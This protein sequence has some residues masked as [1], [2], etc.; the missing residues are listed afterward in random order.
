MYIGDFDHNGNPDM[1]LA[2][3]KNG[4]YY[5]FLGKEDLEKQM[6][7]LKKE[8]L[9]YSKMASK[10]MEEIFGS[11][12]DSTIQ[13]SATTMESMI[14]YNNRK[15]GYDAKPLPMNFQ[16]APLYAFFVDDFNRDGYADILGAGNFYGVIPYEGRYDVRTPTVAWGR[17][18]DG[19]VVT[20]PYDPG[21]MINGEA[22]DLQPILV[23]GKK[24]I[25]LARNNDSPVF[26]SY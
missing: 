15:G 23:K 20:M 1:I 5:P 3:Q 19:Y 18:K 14:L 25:L 2:N 24:C 21:L 8:F 13:L 4:K 22:R 10:T 11:G 16:W 9:S 7:Y 26:L 12:L 17:G 6:P